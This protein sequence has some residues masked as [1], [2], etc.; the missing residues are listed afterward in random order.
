[1]DPGNSGGPLLN[2]NGQVIG[3]NARLT[4]TLAEN[5]IYYLLA[6]TFEAGKSG[7][8]SLRAAISQQ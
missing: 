1:M 2:S 5:G 6:N 7:S 8:Y 4:V 3:V